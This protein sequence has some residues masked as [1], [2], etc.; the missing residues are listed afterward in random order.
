MAL[1][2]K[3]DR[4]KEELD[5]PGAVLYGPPNDDTCVKWH[6]CIFC[7]DTLLTIICPP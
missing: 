2:I 1:T 4:C 5:I 3:C 7:Y 6:I